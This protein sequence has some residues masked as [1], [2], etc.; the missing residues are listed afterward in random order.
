MADGFFEA[1]FCRQPWHFEKISQLMKFMFFISLNQS[2]FVHI[3]H[4][5]KLFFISVSP[6]FMAIVKNTNICKSNIFP[7]LIYI[8]LCGKSKKNS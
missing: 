6:R 7:S 3:A 5:G 4:F 1:I 2:G 8:K